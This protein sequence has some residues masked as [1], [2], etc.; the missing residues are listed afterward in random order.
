MPGSF[1][2]KEAPSMAWWTHIVL[3]NT[4]NLK[5]FKEEA[6]LV[7]AYGALKEYLKERLVDILY[8]LFSIFTYFYLA[9]TIATFFFNESVPPSFPFLVETLA[10][11]YLG[12]L[13]VYLVIKEVERRRLKTIRLRREFFVS[14]WVAFLITAS[15]LSYFE[16]GTFFNEIYKI[17]VTNAFAA[18]IIRVGMFIR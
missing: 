16:E 10:D 14:I 5:L 8:V 15:I 12:A 6:S 13:G 9:I 17:V 11:P 18:I 4:A 7:D 3:R 2:Q 1:L